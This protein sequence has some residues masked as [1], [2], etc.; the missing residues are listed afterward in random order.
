MSGEDAQTVTTVDDCVVVGIG[1]SAGG[2]EAL[3]RFFRNADEQAGV[4]YV[5]L[6]HLSSEFKSLMGELLGRQTK[7]AIQEAD[8]GIRVEPDHIYL[9]PPGKEMILSGRNLLLTERDPDQDLSLP[10]DH[11]FRSLAQDA[12][13]N[14]VAIVLSG[15]GSDGS[16]GIREVHRAGGLVIVQNEETAKFDGM[17]RNAIDT[18]VADLILAP[19]DMPH[20]I[21]E[22]LGKARPGNIE[23]EKQDTWNAAES[24]IARIFRLLRN[25]YGI[26]FAHYKPTTISRRIERRLILNESATVDDYAEVLAEDPDELNRLYRD[27]L[28]GV[29]RFF[30]D[31]GA[32]EQ[33][34]KHVVPQL[35]KQLHG[36]E[37]LRVW[38]AGCASGEEAY[39]LAMVIDEQLEKAGRTG[40]VKIFAT[41]V[42]QHSLDIASAGVYPKESFADVSEERVRRYFDRRNG[43]Y[44]VNAHLRKMIVFAPHNVVKDAPFTSLDLVVCR[45]LLIY[46]RPS[47]Q[48]KVLSL[49]HFGLKTGGVLFLGPSE[50]TGELADEFETIDE[51]W[52][53]FMKRKGSRLSAS[54]GIPTGG[55]APTSGKV[56]SKMETEPRRAGSSL[57]S[58]YDCLLNEYMP[59]SLLLTHEGLLSHSFNGGSKYLKVADGRP[60]SDILELVDANLKI[61]LSSALQRAKKERSA[62]VC[63]GILCDVNG[64]E[65][66]TKITVKPFYNRATNLTDLLV[67][68]EAQRPVVNDDPQPETTISQDVSEHIESL[69]TELRHTKENL[70]TAIE[71]LETTNEELQA[72]N[73]ELV[74]SNEELQSTNEELHSVNEELYTVNAEYQR[75]I[76]ELTEVTDDM[77]NLLNN[78]QVEIIFLDRDLRIRKFTDGVIKTFNLIPQDVGRTIDSFTHSIKTADVSELIAQVLETETAVETEV[79]DRDGECNLL[80]ILP[81]LSKDRVDGVV[82]T[83]FSISTLK[84]AESRLTELSEI[85]EQSDDAILRMDT[86]GIVQTWNAAAVQL[87]HYTANEAV[88]RD[89]SMLWPDER[90]HELKDVFARMH[91]GEAIQHLETVWTAKDSSSV[92]ISVSFSPIRNAGKLVG[93]SMIGRNISD[94]KRAAEEVRESVQRRDNFLAMLSHELRN[95]LA[96]ILNAT[97]VMGSPRAD[98]EM[99]E[100]ARGVVDHHVRHMSRLLD[101]LL[102]VSR[103]TH[104]KISLKPEF[105]NLNELVANVAECVEHDI[106]GKSQQLNIELPDTPL[107]VY[108][109]KSR[110]Q[111]AQV[112]LLGNASKYTQNGG[113]INYRLSAKGGQAVIS[114]EDNGQGIPSGL[115]GHVFEL[116]VQGDETLGRSQGGMGVGLTLV[117]SIVNAHGGTVSVASDGP[118]RGST[119][120]ITL[121]LTEDAPAKNALTDNLNVVRGTKLLLVDDSPGIL[122]MLAMSM[123][124]QGFEVAT[125]EDGTKAI[126]LFDTFRPEIAIIDI[127]L[128]DITGYQVARTIRANENGASPRLIALTG[129]GQDSDRRRALE[130][131]FDLHLV[132]PIDPDQ[133]LNEINSVNAAPARISS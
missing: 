88:G 107:F 29:T 96:A 58:T 100:D 55:F 56:L 54:A 62:V 97:T 72:S 39:S 34:E 104:N 4:A 95:P 52:R 83:L 7:I 5:V 17:P 46:F 8:D 120:T 63:A 24:S 66:R 1:A 73:E 105:V 11:F 67:V 113:H 133:L 33:F 92:D 126:E 111:Q 115:I 41:D 78:T 114:L 14:C 69:E 89:F 9:L 117:K 109:D 98:G 15:T 25:E 70:Q 132:K 22:F 12:G 124:L 26:D 80:R 85:V 121:K 59:P 116:F 87:L 53:L 45:N 57:I 21:D 108:G 123:Q 77:E 47:A 60:T 125:A 35:I 40:G 30:R 76:S 94:Q 51:H 61:A 43:D 106:A 110:L 91:E 86:Q 23:I 75:K 119:F 50:T 36:H 6:Q 28:I 129:Y 118:G 13:P 18:G 65:Q 74:A 38:I 81:Y 122:N 64:T 16:R 84:Q 68:L 48:K 3:E 10:I 27:L 79:F 112:N 42:H 101:D 20:A 32:F 82:L 37:E 128:P 71:E 31:R 49:F 2:L 102:D 99:L 44:C 127:G 131:G 90:Q 19:E 103:I 93:I 130:A